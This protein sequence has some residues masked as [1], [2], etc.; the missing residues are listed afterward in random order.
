LIT[1]EDHE[2]LKEEGYSLV[3]FDHYY[4]NEP[5]ISKNYINVDEFGLSNIISKLE[6]LIKHNFIRT[7]CLCPL[8]EGWTNIRVYAQPK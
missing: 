5:K 1:L 3:Q 6:E 4:L 7:F 8:D 2:R